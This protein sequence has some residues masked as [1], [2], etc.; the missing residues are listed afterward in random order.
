MVITPKLDPRE[1]PF[2]RR[3]QNFEK[4]PDPRIEITSG[5]PPAN[6]P[7]KYSEVHSNEV[8]WALF[9]QV[10]GRFLTKYEVQYCVGAS[11]RCPIAKYYEAISEL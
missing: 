5:K 7:C 11:E 3:L 9:C 1:N 2:M 4:K 8:G 10:L 6:P